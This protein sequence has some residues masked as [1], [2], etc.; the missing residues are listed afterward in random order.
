MNKRR[1]GIAVFSML[2][3]FTMITTGYGCHSSSHHDDP[4]SD[5]STDITGTPTV[6]PTTA[7]PG[8]EDIGDVVEN[9]E[10]YNPTSQVNIENT[11]T[12]FVQGFTV[13]DTGLDSSIVKYKLMRYDAGVACETGKAVEPEEVEISL[14]GSGELQLQNPYHIAGYVDNKSND[15]PSDDVLYL[16]ITDL[17]TNKAV[18]LLDFGKRDMND[19]KT[20]WKPEAKAVNLLTCNTGLATQQPLTCTFDNKNVFWTDYTDEG[21]VLYCSFTDT[22]AKKKAEYCGI[23]VQGLSYPAVVTT[24]GGPFGAV[25]CQSDNRVA[26]FKINVNDTDIA[27]TYPLDFRKPKECN[28]ITPEDRYNSYLNPYDL[29]WI[30]YGEGDNIQYYLLITSGLALNPYGR[31]AS[32]A[33]RSALWIYKNTAKGEGETGLSNISNDHYKMLVDQ[34]NYAVSPF[35]SEVPTGYA[36]RSYICYTSTGDPINPDNKDT[37]GSLNRVVYDFEKDAVVKNSDEQLLGDIED[38]FGAIAFL[39]QEREFTIYT[40]HWNWKDASKNSSI[41]AIVNG[42]LPKD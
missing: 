37:R 7:A 30:S 18:Y 22:V 40:T 26:L 19:A 11:Y 21:K 27:Q 36:T 41:K 31:S 33:D 32:P 20:H 42:P 10:V 16:A 9:K 38:P 23:A 5:I 13:G 29:K 24:T 6:T 15:D 1:L 14:T 2:A 25:S 17:G 34:L 28:Y 3:A 35:L 39:G 12:Y 4:T 8:V